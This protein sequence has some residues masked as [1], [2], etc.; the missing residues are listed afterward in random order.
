[1]T[2]SPPSGWKAATIVLAAV[3]AV[4]LIF[5]VVIASGLMKLGLSLL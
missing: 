3:L 4:V 2:N 5:I 1:M